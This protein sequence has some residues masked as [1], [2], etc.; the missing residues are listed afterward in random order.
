MD[1]AGFFVSFDLLL[2]G[3]CLDHTIDFITHGI[4]IGHDE[5]WIR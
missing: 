4:G 3:D 5:C 1:I 2:I